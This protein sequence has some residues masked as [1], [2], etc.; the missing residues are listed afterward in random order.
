MQKLSARSPRN[1]VIHRRQLPPLMSI[2][3][4]PLI[5]VSVVCTLVLASLLPTLGNATWSGVGCHH[6]HAIDYDGHPNGEIIR[7]FS[8]LSLGC[9]RDDRPIHQ[10]KASVST[11]T[12]DQMDRFTMTM[13]RVRESV[14]INSKKMGYVD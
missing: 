1:V 14:D 5:S 4:S 11:S 8:T 6:D 7:I 2:F 10:E 12:K 13:T 9:D 3:F